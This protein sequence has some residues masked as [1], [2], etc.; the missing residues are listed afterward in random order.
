[1]LENVALWHERDISHSSVERM[2]LPDATA[3]LAFMLDRVRG[4][5][6]DLVVYPERLHRNLDQTGGLWASEGILLALVG[7]GLGRQEAYVLVQR[8][9]M[10]AFEGEGDFKALLAADPDITQ[11]L[12]AADIERE[13]DLDHAFAHVDAIIDRVLGGA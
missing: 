4:V 8:N 3:T 10:K 12:G 9:A 7:K 11:H 2:T 1:G 6:A 13:F 5:I